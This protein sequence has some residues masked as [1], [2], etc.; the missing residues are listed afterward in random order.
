MADTD[1]GAV[2][3]AQEEGASSWVTAAA[4]VSQSGDE[5]LEAVVAQFK[6]KDPTWGSLVQVAQSLLGFKVE[7][8][9]L[10]SVAQVN[11]TEFVDAVFVFVHME[12]FLYHLHFFGHEQ[13]PD[14]EI[15][16]VLKQVFDSFADPHALTY[17]AG[18]SKSTAAPCTVGSTKWNG[19]CGHHQEQ[20]IARAFHA[21]SLP[22]FNQC[23]LSSQALTRCVL[24]SSD[25]YHPVKICQAPR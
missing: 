8:K 14:A 3:P 23:S 11:V 24:W 6:G 22:R 25:D 15:R 18:V 20:T 7:E 17:C 13:Q 4:S 16:A 9:Q 10:F 12:L 21:R 19:Y 2:G 5:E 1:I